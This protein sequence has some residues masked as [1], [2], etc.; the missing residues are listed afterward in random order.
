[1][2]IDFLK[3]ISVYAVLPVLYGRRFL[4]FLPIFAVRE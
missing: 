4:F 1:V 3:G 2:A